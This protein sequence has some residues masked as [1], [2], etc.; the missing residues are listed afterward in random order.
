MWGRA[1]DGEDA[2]AGRRS[3]L[4][5][6]RGPPLGPPEGAGM[7]GTDDDEAACMSA[8]LAGSMKMKDDA[9]RMAAGLAG[10]RG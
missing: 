3:R 4:Q 9:V 1:G 7:T 8:W 2:P 10:W 5:F 6:S